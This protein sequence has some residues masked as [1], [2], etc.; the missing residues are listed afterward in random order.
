MR[1]PGGWI[2][3]AATR[4]AGVENIKSDATQIEGVQAVGP[5]PPS[6]RE[7]PG[8]HPCRDFHAVRRR[9]GW[10]HS[11]AVR[12][13]RLTGTVRIPSHR[14]RHSRRIHSVRSLAS[15]A[16]GGGGARAE[17][18]TATRRGSRIERLPEASRINQLF[19]ICRPIAQLPNQLR[20]GSWVSLQ[21]RK[22]LTYEPQVGIR[23]ILGDAVRSLVD[24][25]QRDAE[26][27]LPGG[28]TDR[29]E[30]RPQLL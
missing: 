10:L 29:F 4:S 2:A 7:S 21:I 14:S 23:V 25:E 6:S 9:E 12:Q 8:R 27:D 13:H 22:K 16:K 1:R 19:P 5:P 30:S 20:P 18:G 11:Q 15:R 24:R 26:H 17:S 3:D 28:R